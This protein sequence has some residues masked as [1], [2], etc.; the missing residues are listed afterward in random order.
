MKFAILSITITNES[1]PNFLLFLVNKN[2]LFTNGN[3]V[4]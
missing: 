2:F 3:H 4:L 1:Y